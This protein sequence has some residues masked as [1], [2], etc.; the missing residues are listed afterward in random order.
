VRPR[1]LGLVL[2]LMGIVLLALGVPLGVDLASVR[3]QQVFLDRVNDYNRFV[4]V[5]QQQ[6]PAARA[7]LLADELARYDEVY[8]IAVAVLDR[9]GRVRAVSRPGLA[10]RALDPHA[11][12]P[13]AVAL[14]GH[15]GEPPHAVWP[16]T[17]GPLVVAE[18]MV[19][20][21]DVV[22]AVVT[23]SPTGRLRRAIALGPAARP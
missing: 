23:M 21:G 16:W 7:S 12:R 14:S 13:A 2:G 18:P 3:T 11:E 9:S 19:S 15:H 6:A 10:R 1:L 4:L 17:R 20:G 5:A 22:G 8:G